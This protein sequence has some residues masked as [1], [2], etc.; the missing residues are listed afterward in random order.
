MYNCF[1]LLKRCAS[2]LILYGPPGTGKSL[3]AQQ[4]GVMLNARDTKFMDPLRFSQDNPADIIRDL[5]VDAKE[6]YKKQ[7]SKSGLYI[8]VFDELDVICGHGGPDQNNVAN[9]LLSKVW[10]AEHPFPEVDNKI[11]I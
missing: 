5:F 4:I 10:Q 9:L 2:G 8:I 7:G 11:G 6:E 3:I 1:H